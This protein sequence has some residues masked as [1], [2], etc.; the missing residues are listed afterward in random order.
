[1]TKRTRYISLFWTLTLALFLLSGGYIYTTTEVKASSAVVISEFI[2]GNDSGPQDEEGLHSDWV[3]VHNT[4]RWPVNL[5]GWALTD[6]AAR[7]DKWMFPSIT[8]APDEYLVV[9]A[10]GKNITTVDKGGNLHTNFKL[11]RT[12]QVLALYNVLDARFMDEIALDNLGYFR[13]ISYG[14]HGDELGYFT[15]PSPGHANNESFIAPADV[16]LVDTFGAEK[17]EP[18]SLASLHP[19]LGS[20]EQQGALSQIRITEIMYHPLG[21]NDYEFIELTNIGDT[22]LDLS[23]AFFDGVEFTFGYGYSL[24]PGEFIV[25]VYNEIAFAQRYPGIPIAGAYDGNLADR[26]ERITLRDFNN[27]ILASVAYD[28]EQGW[29]LSADGSGDSLTL[30]AL[31]LNPGQPE[32][33]RASPLVHGS[34]TVGPQ[35]S[36]RTLQ[37]KL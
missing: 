3:E 28:D 10:S 30:T 12:D 13:D 8:L 31:Y 18:N 33:W 29:P 32:N 5:S 7:P 22:A 34:P 24:A 27:N 6:D 19:E 15:A 16:P 4:S 23:G 26:G 37:G 21:G 11:S 2:A 35:G 25:L 20:W 9:F 14:R 17:E 36:T 1:M